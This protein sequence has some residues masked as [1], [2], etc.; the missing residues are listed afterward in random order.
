MDDDDYE[1]YDMDDGWLYAE[2]EFDLAVSFAEAFNL[3]PTN[4]VPPGRAGRESNRRTRI[5]RHQL[6]DCD[7]LV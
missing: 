5:R 1:D 6:R 4:R 3:Q 2:D 7:G